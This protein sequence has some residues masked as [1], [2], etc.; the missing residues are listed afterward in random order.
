MSR[1]SIMNSK[2]IFQGIDDRNS[3]IIFGCG[4][5]GKI[6][7]HFFEKKN[8]RNK[9]V[10]FVDNKEE[11]QGKKYKGKDIVCPARGR[12]LCPKA[13]WIISSPKYSGQ[14][15]RQLQ[16]MRVDSTDILQLSEADIRRMDMYTQRYWYDED[17]YFMYEY[18]FP[19]NIN[20]VTSSVR[21]LLVGKYYDLILKKNFCPNR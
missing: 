18:G 2:E 8:S 21:A 16:Q 15:F 13:L 9:V 1:K 6:V 14:M 20:F 10:C 17:K 7:F 11:N 4:K 3:V 19:V 5:Y 12:E